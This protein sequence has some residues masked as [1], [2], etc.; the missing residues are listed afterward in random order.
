LL[1]KQAEVG[2]FNLVTDTVIQ[3]YIAC[4]RSGSV[5]DVDVYFAVIENFGQRVIC[6]CPPLVPE[7]CLT[8]MVVKEPVERH[9]GLAHTQYG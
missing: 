9:R 4:R 3:F 2:E 8:D 5:K 6:Q 1:G 7:P